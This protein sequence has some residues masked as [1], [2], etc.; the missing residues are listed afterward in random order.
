MAMVDD[1]I[2]M[3]I[4]TMR[5]GEGDNMMAEMGRVGDMMVAVVLVEAM[6]AWYELL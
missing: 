5:G 6:I 2:I 3:V 4:V 1:H